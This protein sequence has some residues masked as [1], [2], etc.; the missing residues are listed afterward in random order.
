M[1][2]SRH[3]R[4]ITL[5]PD[6]AG[7]WTAA[8]LGACSVLMTLSDHEPRYSRVVGLLLASILIGAGVTPA[9]VRPRVRNVVLGIVPVLVG[10]AGVVAAVSIDEPMTLVSGAVT[11]GA[12]ACLFAGPP[13][14]A[15]HSASAT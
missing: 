3:A 8:I 5:V 4:P 9:S 15:R 13:R 1:A 10:L 11:A 14:R 12:M 2:R 6:G 7:R